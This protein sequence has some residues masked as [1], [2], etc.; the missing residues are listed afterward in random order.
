M[1]ASRSP[2]VS[3]LEADQTI[4]RPRARPAR[5]QED[6]DRGPGKMLRMGAR[7]NEELDRHRHDHSEQRQGRQPRR[8]RSATRSSEQPIPN[9]AAMR[10]AISGAST[11]TLYSSVKSCT[12]SSQLATLS[13]PAFRKTP[14][15]ANLNIHW[16]IAIGKRPRRALSAAVRLRRRRAFSVDAASVCIA[17]LHSWV[18]AM[19][20]SHRR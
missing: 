13:S 7:I 14:A 10:A 8:A 9:V 19:L 2:G 1:V 3:W 11:G 5:E 6:Q 18:M 20:R 17:G 4:E 12:V 16:T 15:I